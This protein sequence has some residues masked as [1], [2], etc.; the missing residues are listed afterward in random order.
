VLLAAIA[1]VPLL[2]LAGCSPED[3]AAAKAAA[4]ALERRVNVA[5]NMYADL[6]VR[7]NFEPPMS[8]EALIQGIVGQA[9]KDSGKSPS[10]QPDPARLRRQLADVDPREKGRARFIGETKQITDVVGDIQSAAADYEAAW[11]FGSEQ[12]VC[13][14]QGVFKL[15]RNLREVARS[16]DPDATPKKR[17][18]PLDIDSSTALDRYEAAVKKPDGAAAATAL[19]GFRDVMR[20]EA[21][22]NEDVQAA[23]VQAAQS[24]AD[25]Y[26]AIE[27]VEN[28]T[29]TDILKIVQRYAPALSRLDDTIDGAAI[30]KKAGVALGKLQKSDDWLKRFADQPIP[31][32]SVKCRQT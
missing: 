15:A 28:V 10:W 6:I 19:Q 26:A 14:K 17:Y 21:K 7:A 9:I 29:L 5:L 18:L 16:F 12:F 25:L 30:A 32:A 31:S 2:M 1:C 8:N 3:A 11:P 22:A 24:A 4:D 20:A 27:S 13:L 23:F